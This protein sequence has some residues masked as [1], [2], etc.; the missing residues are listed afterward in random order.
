MALYKSSRRVGGRRMRRPMR[1]PR[2][3]RRKYRY[4]GKKSY[5]KI[6]EIKRV[7]QL[8]NKVTSAADQNIVYTFKLSDLPNYTEITSLYDQYK[9]KSVQLKIVPTKTESDVSNSSLTTSIY[10]LHS[11]LD[12]SDATA[13]TGINDY[14]QYSTYKM[15]SP[16]RMLKRFCYPKQLQYAYDQTSGAAALADIKNS[17]IRS[18]SPDIQHLGI[19]V[20]I[21][22]STV[23]I[24][25]YQVFA[26]YYV[27]AKQTK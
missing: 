4:T 7:V 2:V 24:L 27:L 23:N 25:A 18:E 11:V 9:I 14:L 22:A 19:K 6:V 8:T 16:M 20:L 26:T 5:K 13:L 10:P 12:F 21:P 3:M 15:T 17:W 1:K